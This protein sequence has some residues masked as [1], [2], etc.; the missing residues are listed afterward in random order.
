[1]L[2]VAGGEQGYPMGLTFFLVSVR[3][4]VMADAN[5]DVDQDSRVMGYDPLKF[6][7]LVL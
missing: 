1:M 5:L 2:G 4:N 7:L 3:P 6:W